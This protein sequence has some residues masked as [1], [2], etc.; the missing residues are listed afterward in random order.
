MVLRR[1]AD[2]GPGSGIQKEMTHCVQALWPTLVLWLDFLHPMHHAHTDRRE[3][4]PVT[5]LCVMLAHCFEPDPPMYELRKHT[6]LLYKLLFTIWLRF[7]KFINSRTDVHLCLIRLHSA[8]RWSMWDTH[9]NTFMHAGKTMTTEEIKQIVDENSSPYCVPAALAV[10]D[11]HPRRFYRLV[12][13][14]L[15]LLADATLA[16]RRAQAVDAMDDGIIAL[17]E[18]ARELFPQPAHSRDVVVG[19]VQVTQKLLD[20]P[21]RIGWTAARNI[22]SVLNSIWAT[23]DR[24]LTVAWA[25]R[26]GVL[27]L[28]TR[29]E[30]ISETPRMAW[31]MKDNH[32]K[33]AF[34]TIRMHG[35]HVCV[36]RALSH[37]TAT[38]KVF[39]RHSEDDQSKERM[40]F[41]IAIYERLEVW[42]QA[43]HQEV[44]HNPDCP[45]VPQQ[46]AQNM[47]RCPCFNVRYCS[48]DCQSADWADHK[49]YC[50]DGPMG[51]S[52]IRLT[53]GDLTFRDAHFAAF[54]TRWYVL[55]HASYIADSIARELKEAPH[56]GSPYTIQVTVEVGC[57]TATYSVALD[58]ELFGD[59]DNSYI[60]FCAMVWRPRGHVFAQVMSMDWATMKER[61]AMRDRDGDAHIAPYFPLEKRADERRSD[62]HSQGR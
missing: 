50:V 47:R 12:M 16:T 55:K 35:T 54:Y 41:D 25:L 38:Q 17:G 45:S 8:V 44:C 57:L 59:Q 1:T 60:V 46:P 31:P 9:R 34:G 58:K 13:G 56:P 3:L 11:N 29:L 26:A 10:V 43:Y 36:L 7:D 22:P 39:F 5:L 19:L 15:V 18:F 40:V 4:V 6:P 51:N 62:Q 20:A 23:D 2:E 30:A 28:L 53:Q 61:A 42:R 49:R 24:G 52:L 33:L 27:P 37:L 32:L 48:K 14:Q 21:N